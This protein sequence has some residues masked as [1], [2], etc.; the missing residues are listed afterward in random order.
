[1]SST[2]IDWSDVIEKE[3]RGINDEDLG[4]VKEVKINYVL[5]Q[6]GIINKEKFYIPKDQ[7]ES[8]DGNILKFRLSESDLSKYHD[9]PSS[10]KEDEMNVNKMQEEITVQDAD[11]KNKAQAVKNKDVTNNELHNVNY[12][13]EEIVK[14][15]ARGLGDDTDFG[16]VQEIL[17]EYIITQKGNV[18]K[19]R[20]YIPKNLV[21]KFDGDTVYF[22]ITKDEA[23]QYKR[24]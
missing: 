17:G 19:D 5:I 12:N 6:R 14:K 1:M 18:A 11:F 13:S 22:K 4:E 2:D 16:E 23:K 8:Y 7:A 10:I 3:A 20:F 24:D 9:E 15:E 21:E